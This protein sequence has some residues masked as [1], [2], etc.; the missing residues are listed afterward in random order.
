MRT[1]PTAC[2]CGDEITELR[3]CIWSYMGFKGRIQQLRKGERKVSETRGTLAVLATLRSL[4]DQTQGNYA[5]TFHFLS[6]RSILN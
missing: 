1:V 5:F 4:T 3:F 6:F 2:F